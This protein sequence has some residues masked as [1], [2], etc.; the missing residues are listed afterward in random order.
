MQ[1][2]KIKLLV[3]DFDG[4][5]ASTKTLYL[6]T[7]YEIIKRH[8]YKIRLQEVR[9]VIGIE[10]RS[11]LRAER[12]KKQ[13]LGEIAGEIDKIV[14][15]RAD[16][17]RACT[18]LSSIRKLLRLYHTAVVS[19]SLVSSLTPFL[20]KHRLNFDVIIGAGKFKDKLEAFS[21]LFKKFRVSPK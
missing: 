9:N 16:R 2:K 4:T 18:N 7:I 12:I 1:G 14:L 10:L 17:L 6:R 8:G 21:Y 20:N 15:K 5:L 11:L 3:L 19:N 13:D